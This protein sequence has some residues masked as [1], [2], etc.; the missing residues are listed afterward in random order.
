MKKV[1]DRIDPQIEQPYLWAQQHKLREKLLCLIFV[2]IHEDKRKS[3]CDFS[4]PLSLFHLIE[5]LMRKLPLFALAR[6]E[7]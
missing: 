5:S 1:I 4:H 6:E 7:Q 3:D 2:N